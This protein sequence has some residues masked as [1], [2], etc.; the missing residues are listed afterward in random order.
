MRIAIT[1]ATGNIGTAVRRHLEADPRVDEI[2]GIARRLPRT[3]VLETTF[4][5]ERGIGRLVD[6]MTLPDDGLVPLREVVRVVEGVSGT[7]PMG[8]HVDARFDFGRSRARLRC[9]EG[10]AIVDANAA[11]IVINA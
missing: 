3:N 6:A 4:H 10:V 8:W 7:V 2:R 9:G 11:A 1:G 5:T